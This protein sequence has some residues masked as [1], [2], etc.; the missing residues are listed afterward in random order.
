MSSE[1]GFECHGVNVSNAGESREA[2]HRSKGISFR[3]SP[4]R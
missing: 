3:S 2:F 1:N 4:C